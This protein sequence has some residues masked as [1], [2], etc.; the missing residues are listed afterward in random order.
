MSQPRPEEIGH[1][2]ELR[3]AAL[4][5]IGHARGGQALLREFD[6]SAIYSLSCQELIARSDIHLAGGWFSGA[7][8]GIGIV[9]RVEAAGG[10]AI[11]MVRLLYVEP[12]ARG[13]GVGE[14]VLDELISWASDQGCSAFDV[15]A[16]PGDREM[17][18]LYEHAGLTA[19][20]IV[21]RRSLL[22]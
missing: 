22:G 15:E 6:A 7:L 21:M 13:V 4:S 1:L 14:H 19:R 9:Q 8:V 16:L 17:K 10:Q 2:E 3:R 11:G 5:A 12:L 18:S 20:K